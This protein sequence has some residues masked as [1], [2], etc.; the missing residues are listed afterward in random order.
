MEQALKT[1]RAG[2]PR[3]AR[4]DDA[5][6]AATIELLEERGYN[7]MSLAA[8]AERAGTS[9]TAIYRR[10]KSKSELVAHAV[11]RTEGDDVVAETDNIAVDIASMVRWAAE[12]LARPAA[13]AAVVG[14]LGETRSERVARSTAAAMASKRV[15]DRLNRAKGRGEIRA[16][17]DTRV[18][19]SLIAGPVLNEVFAGGAAHVNERWIAELVSIILDGVRP[20]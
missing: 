8:V 11:F 2:R 4:L 14:I 10:W 15:I 19:A 9:T 18:L 7:D 12:K 20:Q 13:L 16:D 6:V 1:E 3:D 17:V 5:I